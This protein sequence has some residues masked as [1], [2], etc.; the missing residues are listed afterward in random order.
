M[1]NGKTLPY[2]KSA[3]RMRDPAPKEPRCVPVQ[4]R[5]SYFGMPQIFLQWA[6][7][8]SHFPGYGNGNLKFKSWAIGKRYRMRSSSPE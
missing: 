2:P 1:G 3:F 8:N 4:K 5:I 6:R 7:Q